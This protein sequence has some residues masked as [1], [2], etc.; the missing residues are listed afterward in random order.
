MHE[1]TITCPHCGDR[2]TET[3]PVDSCVWFRDCPACGML[4][5]P[6]PGDC[7]VYC[8]YADRPCPPRQAGG[9]CCS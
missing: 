6:R 2:R 4:L 8:S 5:R 1:A 9:D 7:C 3:M